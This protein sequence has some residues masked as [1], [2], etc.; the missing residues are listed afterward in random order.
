MSEVSA[1]HE[2]GHAFMAIYVGARI[3]SVTIEPDRDDGP[4]RYADIQVEW[5]VGQMT[6]REQREKEIL[7]ALAG[8]AAEM[9][10]TGEPNH[11]GFVSEWAADWKIAWNAAASQFPNERKRLTHL[12]QT[13]VKLYRLLNQDHHW[14]ALAAIVDN[15]LAHETL[16]GEEV[17]DI[18][19]QWLN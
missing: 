8:P 3:C 2:A 14:A 16:E 12:E 9:I 17:E 11:P 7:V 19:R 4:E 5:P 10:H 15:L 6:V 18:V 13:S 1:Y